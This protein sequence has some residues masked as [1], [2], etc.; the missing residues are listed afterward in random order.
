[1]KVSIKIAKKICCFFFVLL[2]L[3]PIETFPFS[4]S[5]NNLKFRCQKMKPFCFQLKSKF[6]LAGK[7]Y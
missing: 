2:C 4:Y 7:I 1:M 6:F 5:Q 3:Q